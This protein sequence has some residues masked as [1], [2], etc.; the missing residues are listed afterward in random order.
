MIP[1]ASTL[2]FSVKIDDSAD[3][4][5]H[6]IAQHS[7]RVLSAALSNIIDIDKSE[8][9]MLPKQ[10]L[11]KKLLIFL[12]GLVVF[13]AFQ[14]LASLVAIKIFFDWA[15]RWSWYFLMHRYLMT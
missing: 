11:L 1:R 10:G 13:A 7:C 5:I 3:V 14:P 8:S 4:P 12:A 6:M 9:G 2:D 15:A